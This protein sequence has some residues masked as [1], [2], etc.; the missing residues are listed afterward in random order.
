MTKTITVSDETHE[1][2]TQQQY[3]FQADMQKSISQDE[4]L[5]YMLNEK[6]GKK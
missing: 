2:F 1:I 6:K 3:D 5:H 4:Y